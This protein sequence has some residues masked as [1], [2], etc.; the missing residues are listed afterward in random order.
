[1]VEKWTA[2]YSASGTV[3]H[4]AS[5]SNSSGDTYVLLN[6][7]SGGSHDGL[8]V[9]FD[10][11]GNKD[12]HKTFSSTAYGTSDDYGVKLSLDDA[13]NVYA[14]YNI[15]P[16]QQGNTSIANGYHVKKYNTSGTELAS[17]EN[18]NNSIIKLGFIAYDITVSPTATEYVYVSASRPASGGMGQSASLYRLNTSLAYQTAKDYDTATD[19]IAEKIEAAGSAVYLYIRQGNKIVRHTWVYNFTS[20]SNLNAED[21]FTASS[22]I[23]SLDKVGYFTLLGTLS[24]GNQFALMVDEFKYFNSSYS[25]NNHISDVYP[26]I[27]GVRHHYFTGSQTVS[28]HEEMTLYTHEDNYDLL[29]ETH[30]S[31]SSV[32][33][34]VHRN[35]NGDLDVGGIVVID[36]LSYLGNAQYVEGTLKATALI[37]STQQVDAFLP[38]SNDDNLYVLTSGSTV[39]VKSQCAPASIE[40][41]ES[42]TSTEGDTE[43]LGSSL[44]SGLDYLWSTG[45]TSKTIDVTT[46]DTYSVTVTNANGCSVTDDITVDFQ[47]P[48]P[49][50]PIWLQPE[51]VTTN[52]NDPVIRLKWYTN[53]PLSESVTRRQRASWLNTG[54]YDTDV[55]ANMMSDLQADITHQNLLGDLYVHNLYSVN[56]DNVESDIGPN[57][58][59]RPC[60][61]YDM[62]ALSTYLSGLTLTGSNSQEDESTA[63]YSLTGFSGGDDELNSFF[64]WSIPAGWEITKYGPISIDVFI[65]LGAE[66]GDVSVKIINPCTG[67]ETTSISKS[68]TVLTDIT[69]MTEGVSSQLKIYPNPSNELLSFELPMGISGT[70]LV[71]V[72]D[73]S[74]RVLL[75]KTITHQKQLVNVQ[76]LNNGQYTLLISSDDIQVA[77]RFSILH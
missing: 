34:G 45:A 62:P 72:V 22:T 7:T 59:V 39:T 41:G 10:S 68:V 58:I 29:N 73:L 66:S 42:F 17:Y 37:A 74:G 32:A 26:I 16:L 9:K 47:L 4:V 35:S 46:D 2:S 14:L 12:W 8:L 31:A 25:F 55:S 33:K 13:E 40:L 50:A 54:F 36:G 38:G 71:Q 60:N 70:A 27:S 21:I 67:V 24:N 51:I 65:A 76:M 44:P 5:L 43:I 23:A 64:Q 48:A 18:V 1:M 30:G 77:E 3:E 57:L 20:G 53:D 52:T 61:D 69:G 15:N 11:E 19:D 28:G 56:S 6:V 49:S 75:T 63:T